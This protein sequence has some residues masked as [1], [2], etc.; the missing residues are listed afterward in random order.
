V[1]ASLTDED[2]SKQDGDGKDRKKAYLHFELWHRG[3]PLNPE[4]YI[5]F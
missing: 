3:D 5:A 4:I 1:I 2:T